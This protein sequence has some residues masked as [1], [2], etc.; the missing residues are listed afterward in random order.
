MPRSRP[1]RLPPV[2]DVDAVV[3]RIAEMLV[4]KAREEARALEARGVDGAEATILAGMALR[5][6]DTLWKGGK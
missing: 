6:A 5:R 4:I 1:R 2:P 3:Q